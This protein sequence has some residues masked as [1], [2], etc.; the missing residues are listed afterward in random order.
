MQPHT[1]KQNTSSYFTLLTIT[2]HVDIQIGS[3][4]AVL[5]YAI[6]CCDVG[7]RSLLITYLTDV[8]LDIAIWC[9]K[10]LII[11]MFIYSCI[12]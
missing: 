9:I 11:H 12:Y 3:I 10:W 1:G 5:V 8:M 2:P 7:C 6:G 4:V